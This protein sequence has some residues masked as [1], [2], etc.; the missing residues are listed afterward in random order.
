MRPLISTGPTSSPSAGAA[1]IRV[2]SSAARQPAAAS[3]RPS[4]I[5]GQTGR[6]RSSQASAKPTVAI[7]AAGQSGG[8]MGSPK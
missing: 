2:R 3:A 7:A 5:R 6:P 1:T 8:S 4:A